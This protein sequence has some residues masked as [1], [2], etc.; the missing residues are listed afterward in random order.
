VVSCSF[1]GGFGWYIR[2]LPYTEI[3]RV[4]EYDFEI[5]IFPKEG[6]LS[7]AQP[8]TRPT[9]GSTYHELDLAE[10]TKCGVPFG[11]YDVARDSHDPQ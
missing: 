10:D 8:I 9:E 3:L 6:T 1:R 2:H 7:Y 11:M 5:V 4:V